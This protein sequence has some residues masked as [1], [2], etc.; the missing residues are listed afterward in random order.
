MPFEIPGAPGVGERLAADLVLVEALVGL[1]L[2]ELRPR[3]GHG[4]LAALQLPAAER[5]AHHLGQVDHADVGRTGDLERQLRRGV[6]LDL[7]LGR[8]KMAVMEAL[9][10]GGARRLGRALAGQRVEQAVHRR[11]LG[12]VLDREPAALLLEPDCLLDEVAGDLLDVAAD[13]ADLGELGRLDLDERRVGELREAAAD[14]GLAAAGG[15][16]HQ[17]VLGRD[18]VAQLRRELLAAPAVAQR[19]CDGLFRVL[20][21]DDV[22]VERG[23]DRLGGEGVVQIRHS[24]EGGNPFI[25]PGVWIPAF[26]GMTVRRCCPASPR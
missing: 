26:A 12:L 14:L 13:I 15:A 21:A 5:L 25:P 18:L 16:D 22:L 6:D 10:E 19:H 20:L 24:R 2:D 3:R 17:D 9:A 23:D 11:L 4:H 1:L 8:V 7:D